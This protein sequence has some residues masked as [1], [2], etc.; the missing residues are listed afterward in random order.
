MGALDEIVNRGRRRRGRSFAYDVE[1]HRDVGRARHG[2][3]EADRCTGCSWARLNVADTIE[4]EFSS[5][6]PFKM[7]I[8]L[9]TLHSD[10]YRASIDLSLITSFKGDRGNDRPFA[11]RL[12]YTLSVAIMTPL[13]LYDWQ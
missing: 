13:P 9:C 4:G 10:G 5:C 8:C 2:H 6:R 3:C 12:E 11:R 1:R 7:S